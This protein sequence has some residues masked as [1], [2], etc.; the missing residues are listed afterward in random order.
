MKKSTITLIIIVGLLALISANG[1]STYN[2]FVTQEQAL[3]QTWAEV[4]TQYQRRFDLIPNLVEAVK[5]YAEHESTTFENVTKARA[6][7]D[8]AY[9]DAKGL[10]GRNAGATQDNMQAYTD[11]QTQLSRAFNIYVNAV[12][13]AYPDLKANEQFL[14]LQTQLE[15]T[16][17]R[18]ATARR[19]YT[20]AVR[21]FNIRIKRFPSSIWASVFGFEPRQQFAAEEGAD[22]APKVQF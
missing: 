2:K 18:I 5:G 22:K 11:A 19:A 6:G 1:C 7:L 17:N 16:E 8:D 21:D 4:E 10:V 12:T 3:D 9:N 20:E 15:G 14:D 13:E